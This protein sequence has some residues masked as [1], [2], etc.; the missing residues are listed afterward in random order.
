MVMAGSSRGL[1]AFAAALA[2]AA[3]LLLAQASASVSSPECQY[4]AISALGPVDES[5]AGDTTPD[6][7]CIEPEG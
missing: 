4:G 1:F 2:V 5:G 6:V 3:A 7:H